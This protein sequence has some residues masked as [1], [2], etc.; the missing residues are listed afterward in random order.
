MSISTRLRGLAAVAAGA[1]LV[2]G[3]AGAAAAQNV[4]PGD[5]NDG[6]TAIVNSNDGDFA[7]TNVDRETGLVSL[8]FVNNSTRS[9]RC[10]APNQDETNR[11]GSTVSTVPVIAAATEYYQRFQVVPAGTLEVEFGL[12]LIGNLDIFAPFWPL[13]QLVPSGSAAQFLSDRVQLQS[14]IVEGHR[15]AA[16][17]GL[18]GTATPFTVAA[19]GTQ[20]WDVQ[21]NLPSVSPRGTDEVGAIIVCG[22]GGTQ[23]NQQ[24]YAWSAYEE[25]EV[26]DPDPDT[27]TVAN[28]SLGSGEAGSGSA[29]SLGS[30]GNGDDTGEGEPGN[31]NGVLDPED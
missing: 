31:G 14:V 19:G 22:P 8:R 1:S 15:S 21:L 4:I 3:A 26:P 6:R 7:I 23:G 30:N 20:V 18:A 16:T 13:L 12:P 25:S 29:G 24:L 2:V 28:G 27:G 9:L 5:R 10:E 17:S 11:P